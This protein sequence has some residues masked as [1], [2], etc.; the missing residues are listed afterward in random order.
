MR[1]LLAFSLII[2]L[3]P[4]FYGQSNEAFTDTIYFMNG[5]ILP[6]EVLDDSQT[7]VVFEFKPR[8]K[9]REKGVHKSEI[10]AVVID[11]QKDI[12]YAKN[13]IVGDDLTIREVEAYMA[14]QRDARSNYN[15]KAV[16]IIGLSLSLGTSIAGEA[17]LIALTAPIIA[18]PLAQYI[19]VIKIKEKTISNKDY[20]YNS[21]YAEGYEGVARGRRVM[22]ALKSTGLGSILGFSVYQLISR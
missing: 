6:C 4:S 21:V 2:S 12:Y 13:D 19:P 18:Y 16:F 7:E 5:D 11:G 17:G 3:T 15:T 20:Q 8:K 1:L 22:S 10:F 14:G 9:L